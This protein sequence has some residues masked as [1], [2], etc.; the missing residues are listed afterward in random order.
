MP[1]PHE[2]PDLRFDR[3]PESPARAAARS[4]SGVTL[5]V[6]GMAAIVGGVILH[7][8]IKADRVAIWPYTG[9][10]VML[11]GVGGLLGGVAL[12]GTR[13]AVRLG[14][15]TIIAGVAMLAYGY[16]NLAE[17]SL[18]F[19]APLGFF[20]ALAGGFLIWGAR[21]FAEEAAK[22]RAEEAAKLEGRT[23]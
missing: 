5:M 18:R 9:R 1:P 23:G 10:L 8:A 11:L 22:A 12:A 4:A 14:A 20:I 21:A 6:V 3:E 16:A 17:P 2:A 15:V 7:F 19:Y 13:A